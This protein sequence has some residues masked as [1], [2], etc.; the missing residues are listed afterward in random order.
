[1]ELEL[2]SFQEKHLQ[3]AASLASQ[4]Y[5][6]LREIAPLMPD[7]YADP[8]TLLPMLSDLAGHAPGVVALRA[9][10]MVG[11]ITGYLLP[12]WHGQPATYSPEWGNGAEPDDGRRIYEGL[13][14]QLAARWVDKGYRTHLV[15]ML[16]HDGS[17]LQGWHWLGFGLAGVDGVRALDPIPSPRPDLE[18]RRAHPTDAEHTYPLMQA[19]Q[20]E[21][22]ESPTFLPSQAT[23]REEHRDWLANPANT[24]WVAFRGAEPIACMGHGPANPNACTI[25]DDAGT[26]SIV[27]AY[28][29]ADARGT[30]IATAL[31]N[32]VLE[33]GRSQGY[34]RCAVDF[35]PMNLLGARF[36][37]KTFQPV[38]YAL[39]RD[40]DEIASES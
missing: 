21:L 8:D 3:D 18:I 27:S 33:W 9:G 13:Y 19:L 10:R 1:M 29:T 17:A 24:L 37:M 39:R 35:E 34:E 38:S 28:T 15:S 30:G 11:F 20:T 40:I 22:S 7:H 32:Q 23:S 12:D 2:V 14:A 5:A 26:T 16:A 25:I 6:A 36:W 31:L 4:R